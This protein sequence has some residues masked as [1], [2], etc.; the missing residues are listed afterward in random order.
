MSGLQNSGMP[1]ATGSATGG[2]RRALWWWPLLAAGYLLFS[3]IYSD[4]A[5]CGLWMNQIFGEPVWAEDDPGGFYVGAAHQLAWGETPLFVGHP[6]STLLPLLLGVQSG[7]YAVAGAE[8]TSFTRFTAQ[9]L[10]SVFLLSKLLMTALHLVSFVA[11]YKLARKM[12][13]DESS[14]EFA[15]LGYATSFPVLYFLSRISVEPLLVT[16]F[17]LAF[18][19]TWR[20]Q[21]LA[22]DHRLGRA[23]AF[24]ALAAGAAVSGAV[25]KFA[26][27]ARCHSLLRSTS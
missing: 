4:R 10:P 14:A 7:L 26:S 18:L 21:A 16:F 27:W 22:L 2:R 6:G 23:L 9:H 20:Y 1:E 3:G 12:L 11:V 5:P 15:A 8:G 17:A 13:D 24:V 25:T 19:A